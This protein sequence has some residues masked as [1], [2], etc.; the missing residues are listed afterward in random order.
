MI[1]LVILVVVAYFALSVY[2]YI[3]ILKLQNAIHEKFPEEAKQYLGERR[4]L[5]PSTKGSLLFFFEYKLKNQIQ[6]DK[7]LARLWRYTAR[8]VLLW[9]TAMFLMLPFIGTVVFFANKFGFH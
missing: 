9:I 6:K 4:P 8:V 1:E 5:L 2:V 3:I 7:N